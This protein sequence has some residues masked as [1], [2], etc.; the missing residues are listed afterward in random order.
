MIIVRRLD[1]G[2]V[3]LWVQGRKNPYRLTVPEAQALAARLIVATSE[4]SEAEF[5][6]ARD[7]LSGLRQAWTGFENFNSALKALGI[8]VQ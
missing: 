7:A 4:Q 3:G 1:D 8:K 5:E 6:G 2:K